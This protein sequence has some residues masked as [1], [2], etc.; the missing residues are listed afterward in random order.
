M[1]V[2]CIFK[3]RL[4]RINIRRWTTLYSLISTINNVPFEIAFK[5]VQLLWDDVTLCIQLWD[6]Y[7]RYYINKILKLTPLLY[8][9]SMKCIKCKLFIFYPQHDFVKEEHIC[10]KLPTFSMLSWMFVDVY[11]F[12]FRMLS[13]ISISKLLFTSGKNL[14]NSS[15]IWRKH[16]VDTC[17]A[18]EV[19]HWS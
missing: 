12:L 15:W 11:T 7:S 10:L 4:V 16:T 9:I 6:L 13:T 19:N 5:L 17:H 2:G 3:V 14:W 18:R 1:S 8:C